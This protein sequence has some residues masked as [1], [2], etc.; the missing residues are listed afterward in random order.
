MKPGKMRYRVTLQRLTRCADEYANIR[1]EWQDVAAVWADIVPV[2][3]REYFT[4][5][6]SIAETQY[7]IYIR[8]MDDISAKMRVLEGQ[9]VYEIVSVL[10]DR[11]SGAITLMAKEV[12]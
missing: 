3:G 4:A 9:H 12:L 6:Q 2:S 5:A 1:D 7:K 8:Y 10:G 11:R